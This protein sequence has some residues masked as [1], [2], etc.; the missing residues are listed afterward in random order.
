MVLVVNQLLLS[1]PNSRY[2]YERVF[3]VRLSFSS[4]AQWFIVPSGVE[5]LDSSIS[6]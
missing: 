4:L 3:H 6:N 2:L 1:I 5:K